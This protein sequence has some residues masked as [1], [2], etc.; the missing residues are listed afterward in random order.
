MPDP[1]RIAAAGSGRTRV[2]RVLVTAVFLTAVAAFESVGFRL[3]YEAL[4][5]VAVDNGVTEGSAWMFPV[6]VDGGIV[7]GSVGVVRALA[8]RRST[9]PYWTVTVGFTLVSWAFNVSHAPGTAGGWAVATVAPLAQMVALEMG[10][11]ELRALLLVKA[12]TDEEP[13]TAAAPVLPVL[14]AAAPAPAAVLPAPAVPAAVAAAAAAPAA[15]STE[16][17][18]EQQSDEPEQQDQ[19]QEE[20]EQQQEQQAKE[21]EQQDQQQGGGEDL[22]RQRPPL[23]PDTSRPWALL[24]EECITEDERITL[25][26]EALAD[27]RKL[28][29]PQWAADIGKGETRARVLLRAARKPAAADAQLELTPA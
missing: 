26:R 8:G 10:M 21:P 29:A 25:T 12:D 23:Q 4:H 1:Y 11:Q 24:Y 15:A 3:S 9:R 18:Q 2:T 6:L 22:Q 5:H 28:N 19:Q 13:A 20:P 7:L 27:R 14:S 16:Q 17:Q